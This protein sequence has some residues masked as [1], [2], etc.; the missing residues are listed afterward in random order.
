MN[1][2]SESSTKSPLVFCLH[3]FLGS[4]SDWSFLLTEGQDLYEFVFVDYTHEPSLDPNQSLILWGQKFNEYALSFGEDRQRYVIG[5]SLGGRLA[6][7]AIRDNPSLWGK[8]VLISTHYGL[9]EESQK[10]ARLK[11]DL[12][13]AEDIEKSEW[14]H[15]MSEWNKQFH[16]KQMEPSRGDLVKERKTLS[17]ALKSWSLGSQ[18]SFK[19]DLV[20]W[21][22]RQLW[23]AGEGDKKYCE[24]VSHLPESPQLHKQ[25]VSESSHRVL[26]EQPE[27]LKTQIENFLE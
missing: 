18:Y 11:T 26:F 6:L 22:T 12:M 20:T 27:V 14:N 9:E 8:A 13:F 19:E 10:Q 23:I 15:V 5:Y 17:Q 24:I 7:H 3:G 4:P 2:H 16:D 1:S 21:P 25:I